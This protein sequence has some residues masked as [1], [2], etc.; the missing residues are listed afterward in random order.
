MRPDWA[1]HPRPRRSRDRGCQQARDCGPRS[2]PSAPPPEPTDRLRRATPS[3]ATAPV[4]LAPFRPEAARPS[5]C[6]DDDRSQLADGGALGWGSSRCARAGQLGPYHLWS[7][8]PGGAAASR[9]ATR[10]ASGRRSG[11]RTRPLPEREASTSAPGNGPGAHPMLHGGT[12]RHRLRRLGAPPPPA[13]R[14]WG[15]STAGMGGCTRC[16]GWAARD[17][18][19]SSFPSWARE[20]ATSS[21][22]APGGGGL[23]SSRPIPFAFRTEAPPQTASVVHRARPLPLARPGVARRPGEASLWCR[24]R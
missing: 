1:P 2:T 16:A 8:Y 7:G 10:T 3:P 5:P 21:S 23:P 20:R 12:G 4:G 19:S 9:S 15:T 24:G 17:S 22:S 18:G 13:S 11:S 6:T 14:W